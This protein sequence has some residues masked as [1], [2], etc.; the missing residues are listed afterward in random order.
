MM[1]NTLIQT[2]SG[3]VQGV[4]EGS[5]LSWKGI[6]YAQPPL[7]KRRFLPPQP[8]EAWSGVLQ[9]THFGPMAMQP[10]NMPA[11][12]LRRLSMS[13]DC[14]TLNIWSKG[15]DSQRRPVLVWIHGGAG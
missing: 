14:L 11:E 5:I 3:L 9:T 7:L 15:A 12:L 2:A 8:P 6:P 4:Q 10:P 13:E 1:P